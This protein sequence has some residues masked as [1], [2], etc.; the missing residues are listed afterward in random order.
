VLLEALVTPLQL[1]QHYPDG[2]AGP[3]RQLNYAFQLPLL[4]R[5]PLQLLLCA[6]QTPALPAVRGA[7][8]LLLQ[9]L[10]SCRHSRSAR[11]HHRCRLLL[12]PQQQVLG[13]AL[14]L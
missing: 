4:L 12:P 3:P 5:L 7:W 13:G 14:A 1:Q 8:L 2:L 6:R 9:L 10:V 11:H